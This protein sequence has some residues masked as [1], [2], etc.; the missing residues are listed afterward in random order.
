MGTPIAA[1]SGQRRVQIFLIDSAGYPSDDESGANGYDGVRVL[2][3]K[4]LAPSIPQAQ[5]ITH[6]GDD[7][8]VAQDSLAPQEGVTA[9]LRTAVSNLTVDAE[10]QDLNVVSLGDIRMIGRGS[11]KQG[12]EPWLCL[13]SY[14]QAID[15]DASSSTVGHRVWNFKI[16]PRCHL[17]PQASESSQG[18]LDENN[19]QIVPTPVTQY[20]WGHT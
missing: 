10:A 6:P 11:S 7:G 9:T 2:G 16:F 20:P 19:Y 4:G 15:T 12:D 5:T 13:I 3:A 1:A 18:G 17:I 14:R 8:I